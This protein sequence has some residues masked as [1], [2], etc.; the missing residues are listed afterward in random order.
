MIKKH[1]IAICMMS[2]A[3]L[4]GCADDNGASSKN[5]TYTETTVAVSNETETYEETQAPASGE[6][7]TEE[8][9]VKE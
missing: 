8:D 7:Q 4:V 1:K 2:V 6:Q 3:F 5:E 9:N